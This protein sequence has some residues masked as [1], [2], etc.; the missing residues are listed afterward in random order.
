VLVSAQLL[1]TDGTTVIANAL[2]NAFDISWR[3]A[4]NDPG[5]GE[6]S[7]PLSEAGAAQ[8]TP[9]RF[10]RCQLDGS[11]VFHWHILRPPERTTI[12]GQEEYGE[13]LRARGPGWIGGLS[14]AVIRP[15][16]GVD[17]PLVPQSR[18]WSFA[19]PNYVEPAAWDPAVE[20]VQSNVVFA[21]RYQLLTIIVEVPDGPDVE[22]T[23]QAPAPLSWKVP[24]AFWIWGNATTTTVGRNYFR[25]SFTLGAQ[26]LITIAATGDNFYTVFLEGVPILGDNENEACWQ[27]HREITITLPAGTYSIAAMVDNLEW[28]VAYVNPAGFLCA[29][30]VP[31]AQ[32]DPASN[33][34]VS[35][36][37]WSSLDYPTNE[38]G[39][40]PGAIVLDI[41]TEVQA[42][43]TLPHWLV[44]F[45]TTTDSDSAAWSDP[46]NSWPEIPNF[47]VPVGAT[48]L[49]LLQRLADEEWLEYRSAATTMTL[50]CYNPGGAGSVT[51]FEFVEGVNIEELTFGEAEPVANRLLVKWGSGYLEVEDSAAITANDGIALEATITVDAASYAEAERK[52]QVALGI[53]VDAEPSITLRFI[54]PETW[55][56][57]EIAD[58]NERGRPYEDFR[59]GD[60][61][62]I[63]NQSGTPTSYRLLSLAVNQA[64]DGHAEIVGELNR[65]VRVPERER[66]ELLDSLGIG[67]KGESRVSIALTATNGVATRLGVP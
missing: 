62:T 36:D 18:I 42:N 3:S 50:Q 38:P 2:D 11:T 8:L 34:L 24:E 30:Y 51:A 21:D 66:R 52:A 22:E 55:R 27:E 12:S 29:V 64:D 43:D 60:W 26:A 1:D 31:D 46:I 57:T 33:V 14:T 40:S 37:T 49:D 7:L 56:E 10:V 67:V 44:D 23:I 47:A 58:P 45:S 59:E 4:I 54:P 6:L 35:D 39:W 63:P 61:I 32:G 13:V 65:R 5:W 48:V 15:Y 16:G 25:S 20:I 28:P 41:R 9:G 17:N 53:M 19:T